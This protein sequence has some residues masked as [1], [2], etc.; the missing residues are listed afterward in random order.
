[1][2][3]DMKHLVSW[4]TG[5]HWH[6]HQRYRSSI[7]CQ[8]P[9]HVSCQITCILS[10]LQSVA[11]S[12][13]HIIEPHDIVKIYLLQIISNMTMASPPFAFRGFCRMEHRDCHSKRMSLQ[14]ADKGEPLRRCHRFWHCIKQ[15]ESD[16]L[17]VILWK[18]T[19]ARNGTAN[20]KHRK[21]V[22]L[23]SRC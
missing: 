21:H 15:F 14:F 23:Q 8:V 12:G 9:M 17:L 1:M 2:T 16:L 19:R 20:I 11:A 18:M 13:H 5:P 3:L 22:A 10:N 7:C 6:S 4:M